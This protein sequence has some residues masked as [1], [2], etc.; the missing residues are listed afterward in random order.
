MCVVSI[1]TCVFALCVVCD[2]VCYVRFLVV[3]MLMCLRGVCVVVCVSFRLSVVGGVVW[4]VWLVGLV[5]GSVLMM[6]FVFC[7]V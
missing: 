4:Y 3:M 7:C 5:C 1:A 2:V 6:C